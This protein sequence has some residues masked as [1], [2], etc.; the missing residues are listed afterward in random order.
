[1]EI[2]PIQTEQEYNAT[3]VIWCVGRDRNVLISHFYGYS[4]HHIL[5]LTNVRAQVLEES[6]LPLGRRVDVSL[7]SQRL[8]Q[9]GLEVNFREPSV[10]VGFH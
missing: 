5:A 10:R 1:M 2:Q 9:H 4:S 8:S 3:L 6:L 7:Q